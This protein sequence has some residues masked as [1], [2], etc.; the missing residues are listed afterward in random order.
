MTEKKSE[1][2]K[3]EL[4]NLAIFGV[5][6]EDTIFNPFPPYALRNDCQIGQWK[7]GENDFKRSAI[8]SGLLRNGI[9]KAYSHA[10][11]KEKDAFAQLLLN[12]EV[13]KNWASKTLE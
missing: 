2:K 10:D 5:M 13:T 6:P 11:H 1:L 12:N 9:L 4:E 8:E 3:T 7:R